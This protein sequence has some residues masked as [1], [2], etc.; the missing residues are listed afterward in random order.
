M[1][2]STYALPR[3]DLP[4]T[5]QL[6]INGSRS[7]SG[8]ATLSWGRSQRRSSEDSRHVGV[9][10]Q[11]TYIQRFLCKPIPAVLWQTLHHGNTTVGRIVSGFKLLDTPLEMEKALRFISFVI[12][13]QDLKPSHQEQA[14]CKPMR[15]DDHIGVL[16][17]SRVNFSNLT[18]KLTQG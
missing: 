12:E 11:K 6:R 16:L 1:N 15:D 14:Q 18:D 9:Q 10:A 3:N 8:Y 4:I 5:L 13:V 2:V 17:S 7:G